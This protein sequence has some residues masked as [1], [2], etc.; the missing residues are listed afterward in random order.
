MTPPWGVRV[1]EEAGTHRS[2]P[3]TVF[4][5]GTLFRGPGGRQDD[6]LGSAALRCRREE[7]MGDVV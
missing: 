5:S 7:A 6:P 4:G 1:S 2:R 3:P